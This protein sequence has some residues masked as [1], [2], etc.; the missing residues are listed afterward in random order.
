MSLLLLLGG[1]GGGGHT[2]GGYSRVT[3]DGDLRTTTDSDVRV[4]TD[5]PP[6]SP[7]AEFTEADDT[8]AGFGYVYPR[9]TLARTED[10]DTVL[11]QGESF[12]NAVASP[13]TM[14]LEVA[15]STDGAVASTLVDTIALELVMDTPGVTDGTGATTVAAVTIPLELVMDPVAA[16]TVE[17]INSSRL[18]IV[19]DI[20]LG[21]TSRLA[22]AGRVAPDGQKLPYRVI[23][24]KPG[25]D[26]ICALDNAKIGNSISWDLN[27]IG[28]VTFTMPIFD[29]K[30]PD[31]KVTDRE[32]Q[33]W[34][35][36]DLL[37][38]GVIVRAQVNVSEVEFQCRSLEWYFTRRV[39]GTAETNYVL[40]G[41]FESG[42]D[43][44][45]MGDFA[46]SEPG[47]NRR[48]DWY[49]Q[50]LQE[51]RF[52]SGHK[53]LY[54]WADERIEWGIFAK[55]QFLWDVDPL[56]NPEGDEW[57]IVAWCYVPSDRW[58]GPRIRAYNWQ[59][60]MSATGIQFQR[61]STT[62]TVTA[63]T[64][65]VGYVTYPKLIETA[66]APIT[67]DTPKD[68]WIRFEL[69]M[70]QPITGDTE[71][72]DILLGTP[73]G[74]VY[75]DC[76]SVVRNEK[77][78]FNNVDQALIAKGL[79]E[80]AQDT[81]INKSDLRIATDCP[82]SG[83]KRTRTYYYYNHEAIS[84]CVDEFP[85]MFNG[86]DWNIA[87]TPTT[88]TF[89]TYY[90]QRGSVKPNQALILGKNLAS[91]TISVD[92]EQTANSVMVLADGGEG[93]AREEALASD[94]S[95]LEDGLILEKVYNATPGSAI[96]SLQAQANRGVKRYK[97]AVT[98]PS[99][100]TYENAG[101]ELIGMLSPGDIVPVVVNRGWIQLNALYRI[102]TI[103]L[104]PYTEAMTL[105]LNPY[106]IWNLEPT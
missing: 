44:W 97:N 59:G 76:I 25:G 86:H 40:N 81:T 48:S 26:L 94:A 80:H 42:F 68:T 70:K 82:P 64:A 17:N 96:N 19:I 55:Q 60:D 5:I 10:D 89:R 1:S 66:I 99:V 73:L 52:I 8:I 63:Y 16:S 47:A 14:V 39:V 101:D 105:T 15:L 11:A 61:L 57:A 87:I 35:G 85:Q 27:G 79:V 84:D 31:L 43:W 65:G 83:I 53:G 90:P 46:P 2:S 102:I 21:M 23:L 22:G 45:F 33:V 75:W 13:A 50:Y 41:D 95:S 103:V 77:L 58:Q 18:E 20:T 92:G 67:E 12:I 4:H 38:Q 106:E 74:G 54:Q 78:Y 49:E 100:T 30:I 88:R 6:V 91:V 69:P 28:D 29:E 7:H 9:G 72:I 62:E 32:I 71:I 3:T 93:A 51:E 24:M 104:D 98:I 56:E 34:R 37:W 36:P